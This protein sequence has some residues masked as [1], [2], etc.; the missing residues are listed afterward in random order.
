MVSQLK[1]VPID[2]GIYTADV[3]YEYTEYISKNNLHR[4]TDSKAKN[5]VVR[6]YV[7]PESDCCLVRLLDTYIHLLPPGSDHFY[8]CPCK[9]Q[10][11]Y[12]RQCVGI[13]QLK[14]FVQTITCEAGVSG[15][16]NHSLRATAMTHMFNQG[17]PEKI[18]ADKSVHHSLDGLRAYDHP[19]HNL[20]KAA[21]EVIADPTR[22][23]EDISQEKQFA[24]EDVQ[25]KPIDILQQLPGFSRL[26]NCT[27]NFNVTYGK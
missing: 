6:A 11:A 24:V 23:F 4:F 3:Y 10:P 27:I 7:R 9:S 15:Y 25:Q 20:E 2:Y 13:N 8:M 17:V 12:C 21:G 14:K 26:N 1:R 19:S 5:K 18:I 16:T 22:S